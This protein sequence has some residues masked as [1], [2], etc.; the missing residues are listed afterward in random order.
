MAKRNLLSRVSQP[1]RLE[2]KASKRERGSS[3]LRLREPCNYKEEPLNRGPG[4]LRGTEVLPPWLSDLA[5]RPPRRCILPRLISTPH[6]ASHHPQSTARERAPRE[7]TLSLNSLIDTTMT[8]PQIFRFL[9]RSPFALYP[10]I[11]TLRTRRP[12]RSDEPRSVISKR[13]QS[14][15]INRTQ[16]AHCANAT[17]RATQLSSCHIH[18]SPSVS[19][20]SSKN[21]V[22]IDS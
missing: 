18:R 8:S 14:T 20:I 6:H 21:R 3:L 16:A 9:L 4:P 17:T 10:A 13:C 12:A 7:S 15:M 19:T 11:P 5:R 2:R 22:S 1:R